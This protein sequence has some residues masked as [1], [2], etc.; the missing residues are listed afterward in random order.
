MREFTIMS[1]WLNLPPENWLDC[2]RLSLNVS[3]THFILFRS[4]G[5]GKPVVSEPLI[6]KNESIKQEYKTKFLGVIMDEKLSWCD[7][8]Q[9]I[10]N[11][12]AKRIGIISKA[13]RLLNNETLCTL[14]NCFVYPYLNY[15]VEIW[16]NI[17]GNSPTD[18]GEITEKSTQNHKLLTMA[19]IRW[20]FSQTLWYHAT[21]EDTF[22]QS[23]IIDVPRKN[24]S[25][26]L[27]LREFFTENRYVHDYNTRQK[28]QFHVPNAKRN[29]LQRRISYIGVV[30]WNY[31]SMYITYN[32]SLASF[33]FALQKHVTDNDTLLDIFEHNFIM[34]TPELRVCLQMRLCVPGGLS[35]R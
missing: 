33:K 3:K 21:G 27:V 35:W 25:A 24:M 17:F 12:I 14:Y 13:R 26:P 16:G 7:H 31:I 20:P 34:L 28:D 32:C 6:I 10:K 1:K 30:I 22:L 15:C 4:Q 11:K 9:Y 29:H 2:N 19:C 18:I 5:I 8:I 23:R